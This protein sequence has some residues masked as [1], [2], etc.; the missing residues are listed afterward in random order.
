MT[1]HAG[2][3]VLT[4]TDGPVTIVIIN[5]P[6]A[7]NACDMET[8]Q[9]LHDVFEAFEADEAARVAVLT[10]RDGAFCAGADLAEL[11]SGASTGFCWAGDD[12]GVTKRRLTKPVI[13]A[14]EGHAV[15]AGLAL[16]VWCDLRVASESA[17]F[18]VFCRRF[19]GP[20]PNGC[21]VRLPRI[22]GES[23]ALDMLMTGRPVEAEEALAFGLADRLVPK[24]EALSAALALAHALA[25]FPQ[26]AMR[27]DRASV[28]SQWD[29]PEAEAIRREIAG[30]MPALEQDLQGGAG[31][32]VG[33]VGRHG[34][35]EPRT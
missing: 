35:F 28:I 21:T 14:V 2:G 20:M 22:I 18:G 25:A 3:K 31:R 15:A 26:L 19:G 34:E 12:R 16:A 24:G 7:R 33:G 23:R 32:F 30:S 8:V 4:E 1:E 11:S 17:V 29:Y 5:R 6:A 13:A 27:S 9:T 10:G